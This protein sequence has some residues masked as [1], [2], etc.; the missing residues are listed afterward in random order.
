MNRLSIYKIIGQHRESVA[1]LFQLYGI[2]LP[3]TIQN[4]IDAI[5]FKGSDFATDFFSIET[6]NFSGDNAAVKTE[7][8]FVIEEIKQHL[9]IIII[10]VSLI[11]VLISIA[12]ITRKR[13]K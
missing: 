9:P 2:D 7:S 3:I 8:F 5:H 6:L 12:F 13:A 10:S 1:Q 11:I 4:V